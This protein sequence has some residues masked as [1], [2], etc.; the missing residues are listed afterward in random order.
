MKLLK[1]L[2]LFLSI[3]FFSGCVITQEF[4]F[5]KDFS[6][7]YKGSIDMS[8][9]IEAMSSLDTVSNSMKSLTDSLDYLLK[10]TNSNLKTEGIS[11]IDLGWENNNKIM[12]ISYSFANLDALNKALNTSNLNMTKH[13]TIQENHIFFTKK[14][15]KTLI[16]NGLPKV[17]SKDQKDLGKLKNYYK[18]QLHFTFERKIKKSNNSRYKISDDKHKANLGAPLYDIMKPD[19]PAQVK[20]KLK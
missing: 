18:Y 4:Y 15:K 12:F 13:D 19:F 20:F 11:K 5:N 9:F 3:I 17:E 14:G 7:N 10:Q 8:Q 1:L 2:I 16:Y 6:G